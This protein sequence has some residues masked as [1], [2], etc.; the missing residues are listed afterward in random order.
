M[1]LEAKLSLTRTWSLMKKWMTEQISKDQIRIFRMFARDVIGHMNT[2]SGCNFLEETTTPLFCK[3]N[4]RHLTRFNVAN[5]KMITNPS[6]DLTWFPLYNNPARNTLYVN[7]RIW[8]TL[9]NLCNANPNTDSLAWQSKSNLLRFRIIEA[10]PW[11]SGIPRKEKA[12][13]SLKKKH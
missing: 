10:L 5:S 11:T 8:M 2:I 4:Y 9:I 13:I 3:A 7:N 12:I 6:F 1:S